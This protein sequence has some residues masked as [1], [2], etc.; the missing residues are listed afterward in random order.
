MEQ[1]VHS[2]LVLAMLVV[3]AL[4]FV[5][6]LR[7]TAPYGRHLRAGWGPTMA[8][9]A[10]WVVM[11]SPA[12]LIFAIVYWS[13]DHARDFPGL[14]FLSLWQFHYL[15]RAFIYPFRLKEAGKRMPLVIVAMGVA[16]NCLNAYVN[17]RWVSQFGHYADSWTHSIPFALGA[18]C[19]VSGWILNQQSDA[20][21]M[22]LRRPGESGYQI[23]RGGLFRWV[24]CPNY[25]GEMLE[26][27]GWALATWSLAG[28]AFAAFTV[29][30]LLPRALANHRWYQ[31]QFPD[32]P[33]SRRALI[34]YLL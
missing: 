16:F 11:E 33:R 17:A 34:P 31:R 21:L 25:L 29:A 10:G 24:S 5:S 23:P 13:G 12:V 4:T 18:A 2:F 32:Y 8:A 15:N 19:F 3:A 20:I 9:R 14:V 30:N 28:L 22:R 1:Q 27:A 6:L 26:W 7:V